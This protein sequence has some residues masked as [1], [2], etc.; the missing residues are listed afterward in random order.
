MLTLHATE[1]ISSHH[2]KAKPVNYFYSLL[3]IK[4]LRII[5]E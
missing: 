4:A 1:M 3:H 5:K 2:V